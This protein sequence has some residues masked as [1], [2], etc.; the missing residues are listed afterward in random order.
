M[1][2]EV[3][4]VEPSDAKAIKEIYTGAN[5]YSGTLQ[6]PHMS[7]E[8]WEKRISNIPDNVYSYLA[9]VDGVPVGNLGLEVCKTPRRRHVASIG[10]A[11]KDGETGKGVGSALLATAIDLSENWLNLKRLE[12]TVYVDNEPAIN[13]YRK[14]AFKI[15]GESEAYAFRNGKYVSAYHMAR[16]AKCNL[17]KNRES[18]SHGEEFTVS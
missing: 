13:L 3:R 10:M 5:A 8:L 11:V 17:Q 4:R 9:L 14:F 1:E 7:L 18:Y 16:I 12:L 2:I 6:L 15:E